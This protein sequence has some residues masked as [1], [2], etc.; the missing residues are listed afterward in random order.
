MPR[1]DRASLADITSLDTLTA[2][3]W[4]ASRGKRSHPEIQ[5]FAEHLGPELSR[6][7]D[8]IL[9]GRAPEGRWTSFRIFD[10]K[11]RL[12]LAPCFRD[13]VL[14][15]A[16]MI[17]MG[18]VLER[19]LVA[20]TFACRPGK[21]TLAAVLRAQHHLR[22]FPWY[23]KVDCRAGAVMLLRGL[24]GSGHVWRAA[25]TDWGFSRAIRL[26]W[27]SLRTRMLWPSA[28]RSL[29]GAHLSTLEE[30]SG[31]G[32]GCGA[33]RTGSNRVIRGG[34]WNSNARN[35]RAANRNANDPGNRNANLGFRV[36]RAQKGAGWPVFDP[37][38]AVTGR[39]WAGEIQAGADVEVAVAEAL[40]NPRRWPIFLW[41]GKEQ[42]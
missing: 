18:P 7:R 34:S 19:A 13:R 11:P 25:W 14:H 36:A 17:P 10:P 21:G 31:M 24:D 33:G 35:V 41:I 5:R 3:F 26:R 6:L 27:R 28:A 22:R 32:G 15:H 23:V 29:C 38:F 40:S 12:I 20:D 37:T 1:R 42:P 39:I 4:Q 2:A 8:D 16:M 30:R 9:L